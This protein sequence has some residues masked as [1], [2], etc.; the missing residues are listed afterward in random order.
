MSHTGRSG[1]EEE[2]SLSQGHVETNNLLH[3]HSQLSVSLTWTPQIK[4]GS[5]PSTRRE[6]RKRVNPTIQVGIKP[7][8]LHQRFYEI[9]LSAN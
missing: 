3:S 2:V 5:S 4:G 1:S 9:I 7:A 6:Q 8:T